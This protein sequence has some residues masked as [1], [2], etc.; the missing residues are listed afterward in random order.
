MKPETCVAGPITF[1]ID[2]KTGKPVWFIKM[3]CICPLA[4]LVYE[5]KATLRKHL[6]SAEKEISMLLEGLD[7]LEL[8]AILKKDEPETFRLNDV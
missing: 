4:A 5:N 7:P 3:D 2:H 8:A 1:D 6:K